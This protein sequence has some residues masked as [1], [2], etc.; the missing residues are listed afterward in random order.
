VKKE[1]EKTKLAT[2]TGR[3]SYMGEGGVGH[4]QEDSKKS[5]HLH[6]IPPLYFLK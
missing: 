1:K 4:K 5:G 3:D 2:H 6:L